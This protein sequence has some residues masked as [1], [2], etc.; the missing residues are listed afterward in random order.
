[1]RLVLFFAILLFHLQARAEWAEKTLQEMTLDEKVGQLFMIAGYVDQEYAARETE[2]PRIIEEIESYV[3]EYAIGGIGLVGPS[4]STK[5]VILLNRY[6]GMSKYP[7]LI[8]QDFEWGLSMRL[9]DGMRFPKNI[10]LGALRDN[11]LLYEMGKEIGRQGKLVGVQMNLSPDMDVNI[12]PENPVINVRSFGSSP[13]EV[14]LKGIAMIRGLQDADMIASAKHFPGLGDITTDPHL[15]LPINL[16]DKKRLEEIELYPFQEAVKAGVLSIQTDHV[17]MPALEPDA[18]LPSSLSPNI[19]QGILKDKIGFRGLVLSGALRMKALSD[20]WSQEEIALKAFVAGSDM[21]LMPKDFP[22]AFQAIK[23]AVIEGK[24]NG[25]ALDERVLKILKLKEQSKL[26]LNRTLPLPTQDQLH[27]PEAKALKQRLYQAVVAVV[28]DENKLLPITS[29]PQSPVAYVQIGGEA[30]SPLYNALKAKLD[31]QPYFLALD[32][33]DPTFISQLEK[34]SKVIVA[35]FPLDAR[36]IAQIRL[37]NL[38]KRLEELKHFRI[39]GVQPATVKLIE[40]LQALNSKSCVAFFGNPFGLP[41][42]QNFSS[43]INGF[44]DDPE[45]QAAAAQLLLGVDEH[46]TAR[47]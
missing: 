35:L 21:L 38:E 3:K 9:T 7:L 20:N 27:T 10:T 6:Q 22:R 13:Q 34:H 5:Q 29:T 16:S 8:A 4:S 12:E 37:L 43:L 18:K 23:T 42:V 11:S 41:F 44:E 45:A 30:N 39:H 33:D 17:L 46:A 40:K 2:N 36:R 14:A 47:S 28:K 15:A 31:I 26:H 32:Y 24:I 1:M 19:V 25:K